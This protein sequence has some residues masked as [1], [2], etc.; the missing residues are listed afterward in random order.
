MMYY[1]VKVPGSSANIGPGFD[2]LGFAVT[3]YIQANFE[4]LEEDEQLDMSITG[5][6]ME[7]LK[8]DKTNLI[9]ISYKKAFD[10][11]NEKVAG[12]KIKVNNGIPISRGLGSSSTAIV[13]GLMVA[14]KLLTIPL[15][16][17]EIVQLATEL[18]GH[19]DNVTAALL[20]GIVLSNNSEKK[21][22]YHKLPIIDDLKCLALVPNY[23]FFTRLARTILPDK[24]EYG[25][26]IKN[27]CNT[28]GLIA[29]FYENSLTMF[30]NNLEDYL[31]QPYRKEFVKGFELISSNLNKY[32][33]IG[34]TISGSG[35]TIMM[36]YNEEVKIDLL[37][38]DITEKFDFDFELLK[39]NIDTEG[40]RYC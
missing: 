24:V 12:L 29:S 20:G 7:K 27:L 18:E 28:A 35:P 32:N 2:C 3:I 39:L 22:T 16:E 15:N 26:A 23:E 17:N 4:K 10:Y 8:N 31:H 6:G 33:L 21:V 30:K 1:T 25:C 37:M 19:S 9:Y 38:K 36:F 34:A 5:S 13:L 40:A 11:R 14:N